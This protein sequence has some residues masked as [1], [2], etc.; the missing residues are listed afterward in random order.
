MPEMFQY[1]LLSFA[2]VMIVALGITVAYYAL[3]GYRKL[4]SGPMLWYSIGFILF[5][6]S[7]VIQGVLFELSLT[8]IF[9]A[10][11]AQTIIM[12]TGMVFVLYA[13]WCEG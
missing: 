1:P 2:R 8:S 11:Y 10:I 13:L 12:A 5:S 9:T 7:M 3:E 6:L 4:E